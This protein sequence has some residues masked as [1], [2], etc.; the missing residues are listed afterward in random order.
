M[1]VN[2]KKVSCLCGTLVEHTPTNVECVFELVLQIGYV[3]DTW[4]TRVSVALLTHEFFGEVWLLGAWRL[5][6]K[7]GQD[8][9]LLMHVSFGLLFWWTEFILL[10]WWTP[11]K[12]QYILRWKVC[13]IWCASLAIFYNTRIIPIQSLYLLLLFLIFIGSLLLYLV[14]YE[15]WSS[16]C[17]SSLVCC[18]W[19]VLPSSRCGYFSLLIGV[20]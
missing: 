9:Y 11:L 12:Q 1:L 15:R 14:A 19:F 5:K 20:Y 10:L 17:W 6:S 2:S 7:G 3:L 8:S 16:L 4:G 13:P 18:L